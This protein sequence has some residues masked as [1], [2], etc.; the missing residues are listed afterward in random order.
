M[1]YIPHY[2]KKKQILARKQ[3][4][5]RRLIERRVTPQKLISAADAIREARIRVLRAQRATIPPKGDAHVLFDKIDRKIDALLKMTPQDIL[6]H[7]ECSA[8]Q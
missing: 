1:N 4:R 2:T 5:L 7:F 3:H 8:D 6:A